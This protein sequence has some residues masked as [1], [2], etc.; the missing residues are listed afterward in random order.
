MNGWTQYV[1]PTTPYNRDIYTEYTRSFFVAQ[2]SLYCIEMSEVWRSTKSYLK[3]QWYEH[4]LLKQYVGGSP[5]DFRNTQS[6]VS[7]K[8]SQ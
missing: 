5:A 2:N 8:R 1:Q 4:K 7:S 3:I 6:K